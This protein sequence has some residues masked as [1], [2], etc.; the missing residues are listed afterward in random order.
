MLWSEILL[1]IGGRDHIE[2]F[3]LDQVTDDN[4]AVSL[5]EPKINLN[6][7]FDHTQLYL[8]I[9]MVFLMQPLFYMRFRAHLG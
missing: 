2:E 7:N 9:S 4:D 8:I 6:S 5:R 1:A 3:F